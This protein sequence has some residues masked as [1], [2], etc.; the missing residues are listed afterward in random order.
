MEYGKPRLRQGWH[1]RRKGQGG[2]SRVWRRRRK[3][4]AP[5]LAAETWEGVLTDC[6]QREV[7]GD[8]S[9]RQEKQCLQEHE[10]Q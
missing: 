2:G 10:Q 7:T 5:K 3:S 1:S 8:T 4:L 9:P 6:P